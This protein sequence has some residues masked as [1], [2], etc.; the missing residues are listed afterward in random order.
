MSLVYNRAKRTSMEQEKQLTLEQAKEQ[1]IALRNHMDKIARETPAK[2]LDEVYGEEFAK[3]Y[4]DATIGDVV[5]QDF[6]GYI[7]K[8]GKEG[9]V[10]ENIDLSMQWLILAAANGNPLSVERLNIFLNYAYDEIVYQPDF[11]HLCLRNQITPNNYTYVIGKL[12]C[13]A[14]VDDL[15]IS[16]LNIIKEIP[17]ELLFNSTTMGM[18]DKARNRAIP[19]VLNFLRGIAPTSKQDDQQQQQ[20]Q[21][22]EPTPQPQPEKTKKTIAERIFKKK[23]TKK[24]DDKN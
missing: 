9:L 5:A 7:F 15:K 10:P 21:E 23:D 3:V 17:T 4:T 1:F 8:R 16:A 2:T 13:E 14:I 20:Q 11:G 22:T 19:V 6:L 18:Y 24:E 12:L